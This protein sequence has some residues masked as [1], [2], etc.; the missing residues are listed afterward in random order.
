M[1]DI[2]TLADTNTSAE[3]RTIALLVGG[4]IVTLV[5]SLLFFIPIVRG[6]SKS[7]GKAND[8]LGEKRKGHLQERLNINTKDEVGQMAT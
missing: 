3:T 7:L 1:L 2:C 5:I 4:L 8:M 6:I